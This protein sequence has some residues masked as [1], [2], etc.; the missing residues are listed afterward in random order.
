[1]QRAGVLFP[2]S[3]SADLQLSVTPYPGTSNVP[4]LWTV[5]A[6]AESKNKTV[7]YLKVQDSFYCVQMIFVFLYMCVNLTVLW[8]RIALVL[9]LSFLIISLLSNTCNGNS[10]LFIYLQKRTHSL[11]VMKRLI[12]S[13]QP[14]GWEKAFTQT[15]CQNIF[16]FSTEQKLNNL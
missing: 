8:C 14:H 9:F 11:S 16:S 7:K 3:I 10:P 12:S 2:A 4:G 15:L 6:K 1:M 13:N 5:C